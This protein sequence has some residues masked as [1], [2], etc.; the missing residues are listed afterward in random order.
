MLWA[1][2]TLMALTFSALTYA[3]SVAENR[4]V[5]ISF[6]LSMNLTRFYL[7]AILSL[8][9][10]RMALRFPITLRP[11]AYRHLSLNVVAVVLF[12]FVHQSVFLA[13]GWEADP[14]FKL[15]YA[16][17]A[18]F[19]QTAFLS[20][21][22]LNILLALLI[23]ISQHAFIL[24][25]AQRDVE[26][27]QSLLRTQLVQA[28][29]VA[30]KMQL[31]PHF[32][33]NALHSISALVLEDPTRANQMISRLGDFLRL[34]LEQ[35]ASAVPLKEE[36]EF[37][38]C[39]LDIEQIRFQDRLS[40]SFAIDPTAVSALVPH[41]ILQPLVEN[42]V[43]HVVA[44]RSA[45]TKIHV[46]ASLVQD[47]LRLEVSDDGPGIRPEA[48]GKDGL[49]INNVRARL[50]QAYGSRSRFEM[51]TGP[52]NGLTVVVELPYEK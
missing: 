35:S 40:V 44:P 3:S 6:A 41:L 38:R 52:L 22:Y 16:T 31:H 14:S 34:T 30:L 28:E 19:Y 4:P 27:Q 51:A 1:G 15:R 20:G 42:A 12:A 7:W 36:I 46:A 26:V 17:F 8:A 45:S 23:V 9:V 10:Y 24:Y 11:L 37:L 39:Y 13:I 50:A 2:W 21:L 5:S 18:A 25:R 33:F 32:L 43:R 47:R 48:N 29:L 49:G